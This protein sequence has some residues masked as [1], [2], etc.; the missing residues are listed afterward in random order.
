M[1]HCI[2]E[3]ALERKR[4]KIIRNKTEYIE[5]DFR[6]RYQKVEGMRKPITISGDR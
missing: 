4:L 6:G 2:S 3:V 1:I 5:Y